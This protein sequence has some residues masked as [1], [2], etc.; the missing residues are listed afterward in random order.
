MVIGLGLL[1][2]SGYA[3]DLQ[4]LSGPGLDVFA[5]YVG[6]FA[7]LFALYLAAAAVVLRRPQEDPDGEGASIADVV[8]PACWILVQSRSTSTA[9]RI[10]SSLAS[11]PR[12]HTPGLGRC[13]AGGV[14]GG[15]QMPPHDPDGRD[16][17]D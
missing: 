6:L 11:D 12:G 17:R 13:L 9:R 7:A 14:L 2:L 15:L 5:V 10:A 8:R 4:A 3:L 16:N 1:S